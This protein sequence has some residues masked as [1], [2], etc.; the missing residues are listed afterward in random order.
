MRTKWGSNRPTVL[1]GHHA[2]ASLER[3]PRVPRNPQ[4]FGLLWSGTRKILMGSQEILYI[5]A[6]IYTYLRGEEDLSE[7]GTRKLKN[8]KRPLKFIIPPTFLFLGPLFLLVIKNGGHSSKWTKM[9]N[10]IYITLVGTLAK[11]RL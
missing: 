2:G 1:S 6:R 7:S 8:L 3:V 9:P 4:I 11:H 10:Q 5:S